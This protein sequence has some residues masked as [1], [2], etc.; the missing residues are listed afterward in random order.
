MRAENSLASN[1]RKKKMFMARIQSY[2]RAVSVNHFPLLIVFVFVNEK[3]K[4]EHKLAKGESC[5]Q[6]ER[7][8]LNQLH[9][10]DSK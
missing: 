10:K 7:R 8:N 3:N 2:N 5:F 9:R 4:S 1:A 6:L